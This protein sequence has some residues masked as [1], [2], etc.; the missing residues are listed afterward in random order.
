[1]M[2]QYAPTVVATALMSG[3]AAL[4]WRGGAHEP[5]VR[6]RDS[7]YIMHLNNSFL[8]FANATPIFTNNNS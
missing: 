6:P 2:Q 8:F 3:L 4:P 1:M 5:T 7:Y